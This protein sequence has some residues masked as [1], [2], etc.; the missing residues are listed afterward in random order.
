[1]EGFPP[2]V[3]KD[4]ISKKRIRIEDEKEVEAKAKRLDKIIKAKDKDF[5]KILFAGLLFT[6]KE[7]P[8]DKEFDKYLIETFM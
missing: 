7:K 4:S 2:F 3:K 6:A 8:T 1:M 5:M